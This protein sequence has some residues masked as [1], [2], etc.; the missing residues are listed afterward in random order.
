MHQREV[1]GADVCTLHVQ[2]I[3]GGGMECSNSPSFST[4]AGPDDMCFP[5]L[6]ESELIVVKG[7]VF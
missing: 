6:A 7:S 5:E 3:I 1:M 2:S 4:G